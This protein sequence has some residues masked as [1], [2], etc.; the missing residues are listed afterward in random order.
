MAKGEVSGLVLPHAKGEG[1][2]LVLPHVKRCQGLFSHHL[3]PRRDGFR[4]MVE[5]RAAR[6]AGVR[7]PHRPAPADK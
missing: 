4:T 5:A 6:F 7:L 1:S 3:T 2:G